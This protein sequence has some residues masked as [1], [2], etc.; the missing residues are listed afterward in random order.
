MNNQ[1]FVSKAFR[2]FAFN[3]ILS[4]VGVVLGTFVDA[5]ILGNV[6]GE[7]GLSALAVAM[8][9]Y[10]IYNLLAFAFGIGGSLAVSEAIGNNDEEQIKYWFFQTL[11]FTLVSGILLAILGF[12]FSDPLITLMGGAGVDGASNYLDPV[13]VAAPVFIMAPVLSLLIRSDADPLLSTIGITI[14]VIVN[15]LLD[16]IFVIFLEW[17]LAGAAY[18]MVI[19][20]VSAILVY[21]AHFIKKNCRLKFSRFLVQVQDAINLFKNGFGVASVYVYQGLLLVVINQLLSNQAGAA[22]LAIYSILFN[23]SLFAYA[24]F[25]GV[26]LALAP[27]IGTFV[28]EKDSQGVNETMQLAIKTTLALSLFCGL[29]LFF[30]AGPIGHLFGVEADL[31]LVI[32]TIRI[33]SLSVIQASL[34]CV[35][36]AFYQ[37]IKRNRLASV[38]FLFR[39]LLLPVVFSLIFIPVFGVTGTAMAMVAAETLTSLILLFTAIRLK[40]KHH[41]DSL[42]LYEKPVVELENIYETQLSKD[43]SKLPK[44]ADEIGEFCDRHEIDMKTAYYINLTIEELSAN[45][46]QFGFADGKEHY[47][48]IKI[49]L[50]EED[51][52]I[53]LRDDSMTYNPFEALDQPD[54]AMD[55]LGVS[56]IRKKAK[57]FA[58]NRTLVFNNLLII[59]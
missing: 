30:L 40:N 4:S 28:G 35:M 53:R 31:D 23:V 54:E 12:L 24:V 55:Y 6:L 3:S 11:G 27:L 33:S 7:T 25:D 20:Q 21:G 44:M 26:S 57:D 48:S 46:I 13:F 42:L 47:I 39:G 43:L 34:N 38:L 51:I 1:H 45:I 15:L 9:V 37:T 22:G 36:A 56:I 59:L 32:T 2:V 18:A 58:Y 29:G 16:I 17:G 50:F 52:Y 10:M 41:F 14:S 8:P 19:G 49:A 5:V